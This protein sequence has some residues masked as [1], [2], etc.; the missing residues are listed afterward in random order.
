MDSDRRSA[1]FEGLEVVDT[2]RGRR[3]FEDEK[4]N[5]VLESLQARHARLR[6]WRSRFRLEA[7]LERCEPRAYLDASSRQ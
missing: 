4:L 6:R 1:Q 5:I 2:G 7:L 3:W